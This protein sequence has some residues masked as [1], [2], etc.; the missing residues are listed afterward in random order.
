MLLGISSPGDENAILF[1]F[2]VFA[3]CGGLAVLIDLPNRTASNLV[4]SASCIALTC[5]GAGF[6]IARKRLRT[7]A[8]RFARVF[9]SLRGEGRA[10]VSFEELGRLCGRTNA[11]RDVR[12]MLRRNYLHNVEREAASGSV[13]LHSGMEHYLGQKK[14]E[15]RPL[16]YW[17]NLFAYVLVYLSVLAVVIVGIREELRAPGAVPP[18]ETE[19]LELIVNSAAGFLRP[20]SVNICTAIVLSIVLA[21]M[22]AGGLFALWYFLR[23]M[24]WN[25]QSYEAA[26]VMI[27]RGPGAVPAADFSGVFGRRPVQ[28]EIPKMV[29][30]KFLKNLEVSGDGQFVAGVSG[31]SRGGGAGSRL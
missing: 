7:R 26:L 9:L 22:L 28:K 16:T 19:D 6:V 10:E 21:V 5:C 31:K 27:R 29:K 2:L 30:A 8:V 20:S 11:E 12:Q 18:A 25:R 13:L 15:Y 14:E 24:R 4:F 17:V 23:D 3:V 1:L